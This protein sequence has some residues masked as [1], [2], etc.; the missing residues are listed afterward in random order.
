MADPAPAQTNQFGREPVTGKLITSAQ[1]KELAEA[2]ALWLSYLEE[3]RRPWEEHWDEIHR[4]LSP[5]REWDHDMSD[6][7]SK[8]RGAEVYDGSPISAHR[9][10]ANG[11][12][13]HLV[14]EGMPWFQLMMVNR[15][16]EEY[17]ETRSWLQEIEQYLYAAYKRSTFYDV[18][19]EAFLD[20]GDI[21]NACMRVEE[22][23]VNGKIE[24]TVRHPKETYIA[25]DRFGRVDGMFNKFYMTAREAYKF[26]GELRLSAAVVKAYKE[27]NPFQ[28]YIF[29]RAILPREE[30]V[31]GSPLSTEMPYVAFYWQHEVE[32]ERD[33]A[34]IKEE[35]YWEMPDV[36]WRS[37]KQAQEKYGRG[38]GS[39]SLIEIRGVNA[40][41]KTNMETGEMATNPPLQIPDE[42]EDPRIVP[43][44]MNYYKQ[45]GE[46]IEPLHLASGYTVGVDQQDRMNEFIERHFMVQFFTM[47]TMSEKPMTATEIVE[48]QGEKAALL[49]PVIG[50]LNSEF[51]DP[52]M[53]RFFNIEMRAG[54]LPPPPEIIMQ[55]GGGIE[56]NYLG[57]LAQAQKRLFQSHG[58]LR[59][60]EAAMPIIEMDPGSRHVVNFPDAL[61]RLLQSFAFPESSIRTEREAAEMA[62]AE[63]E[64]QQRQMEVAETAELSK[65]AANLNQPVADDSLAEVV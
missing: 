42:M 14:T 54:R 4:Y 32:D 8:K 59:G 55:F 3:E 25:L 5:W 36:Y 23:I 1:R 61:R 21:G 63:A 34:I 65:A 16:L 11:M 31:A 18:L 12:Q 62:Q 10:R 53:D 26:F 44:G 58:I 2:L 60:L 27:G 41:G 38:P 47:L 22:N 64:A 50:R 51:L 20:E 52:I 15:R 37:S 45:R 46:L 13:G 7:D 35:G 33:K 24:C 6:D 30:H 17:K 29:C 56:V 39:H 40:A 28:K 19:N 9:I 43:R 48:K 57:P 49:G